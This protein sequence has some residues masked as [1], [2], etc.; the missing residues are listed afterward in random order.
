MKQAIAYIRVSSAEQV[1]NFSLPSQGRLCSEFCDKNGWKLVAIFIEWGESAQTADR[2]TLQEMLRYCKQRKNT[3]NYVVVYRLD[4]FARFAKDHAM[5][6]GMLNSYGSQLRSVTEPVDE[7]D[8]GRLLGTILSGIA[9][10]DNRIRIG[11]TKQGMKE[12]VDHGHWPFGAPT[13]GYL[14][15]R[16]K[17]KKS[18][19]AVDPESAPLIERGFKQFSTGL[20]TD[21]EVRKELTALGLRRRKGNIISRQNFSNILRNPFYVGWL[22]VGPWGE[23]KRGNFPPL[24]DQE[25]FDK[26]QAILDGKLPKTTPESLG[27]PE[28]PLRRYA[29][30]GKCG[31]RLTATWVKGGQGKRYPYYACSEHCRGIGIRAEELERKFLEILDRFRMEPEIVALFQK[32]IRE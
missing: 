1:S 30:C 25:T 32:T 15:V 7:S 23:R 18:V 14:N 9:E 3:I 2:T 13:I 26:V 20:Y 12:A 19:V 28:F 6:E 17:D 31:A 21:L 27:R 24:V 22:V 16:D 10:F 8:T 4:R 29:K 11:R 5:L